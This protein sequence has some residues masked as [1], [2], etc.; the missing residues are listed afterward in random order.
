MRKITSWA[1]IPAAL[2]VAACQDTPVSDDLRADLALV[3][4]A[5]ELAPPGGVGAMVVSE[6]ENLPAPAPTMT[7]TP[8]RKR[9]PK[10][11]PPKTVEAD[12]Q[13]VDETA[14]ALEVVTVAASDAPVA[15]EEPAPESAPAVRPQPIEPRCPVGGGT[16]F[17]AGPDRGSGDGPR[18]GPRGGGIGV[19]IRG[20]RTGRDPC[21][22]HDQRDRRGA[23]PGID[24][25]INDRIPVR[26]TFPRY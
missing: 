24:I 6:A 13:S 8:T 21:A 14:T 19:V 26:P 3:S 25:L 1:V 4:A 22:I 12:A 9:A 7:P 2:V 20:G 10:A 23:R 11:P 15:V 16:V 18:T 17:G 5:I